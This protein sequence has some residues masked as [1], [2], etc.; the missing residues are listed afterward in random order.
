MASVRHYFIHSTKCASAARCT[1][2]KKQR[3]TPLFCI[4]SD[5]FQR[6]LLLRTARTTGGVMRGNSMTSMTK[7]IE[8]IADMNSGDIRVSFTL[9]PP[10]IAHIMPST[11]PV[12]VSTP[13]RHA[14]PSMNACA[15]PGTPPPARRFSPSGR[16][17]RKRTT[18]RRLG[19]RFCIPRRPTGFGGT[20]PRNNV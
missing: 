10:Y 7:L 8:S 4:R 2:F 3:Q 14:K 13:Q 11:S 12:L 18:P 17:G 16:E 15:S 19:V 6:A 1:E 9:C 5:G 20:L